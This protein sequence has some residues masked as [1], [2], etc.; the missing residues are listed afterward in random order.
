MIVI[1]NT[2]PG[3]PAGLQRGVDIDALRGDRPR[4]SG[5]RTRHFVTYRRDDDP[6]ARQCDRGRASPVHDITVRPGRPVPDR[7]LIHAAELSGAA[8]V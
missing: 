2:V 4:G 3:K 1:L 7:S 8:T 5:L 6:V